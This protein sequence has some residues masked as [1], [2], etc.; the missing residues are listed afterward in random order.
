LGLAEKITEIMDID[1]MVPAVSQGAIG[2][3]TRENDINIDKIM[4]GINFTEYLAGSYHFT[5]L[6]VPRKKFIIQIWVPATFVTIV[7]K[8]NDVSYPSGRCRA[9][10]PI[11]TMISP[12]MRCCAPYVIED[13]LGVDCYSQVVQSLGEA[14]HGL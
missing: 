13:K 10:K 6:N 3:E 9:Q 4:K 12:A 5:L 7:P 11:E 1:I 2:I 14:G 8:K